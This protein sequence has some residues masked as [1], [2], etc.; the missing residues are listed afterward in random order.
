VPTPPPVLAASEATGLLERTFALAREARAAGDHPFGALL[1]VDGVVVAEAR[2]LVLTTR[3]LTAH[4]ETTLVRVLER[5]GRLALLARGVVV[6]SCEPCPLCVGALFWAGTRHIMFGLSAQRLTI[7]S[8]APGDDVVGF[9]ITAARLAASAVP[10]M[11]VEG[12]F[13]EDEAAEVHA[14]FWT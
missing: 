1:A 2:N 13:L 10:P 8:S 11:L 4:A 12:P 9:T 3:D 7:L 5:E 6:A 14:G